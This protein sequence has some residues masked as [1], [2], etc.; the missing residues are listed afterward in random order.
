[1]ASDF[2]GFVCL[3]VYIRVSCW[4]FALFGFLFVCLFVFKGK[5]SKDMKLVGGEV[6]RV[7]EKMGEEESII[8][9]YCMK[10]NF[11]RN[12]FWWHR[13]L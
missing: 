8:R 9:I 1:M 6:S 13:A 11:S 3:C 7:W 10:R 4:A 5:G 2:A 12:T